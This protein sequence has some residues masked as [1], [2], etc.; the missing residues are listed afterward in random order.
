MRIKKIN[1][2][3]KKATLKDKITGIEL[4]TDDDHD[5][6]TLDFIYPGR[7]KY[8]TPDFLFYNVTYTSSKYK[9]NFKCR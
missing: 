6:V 9:S 2:V 1:T 8:R 4:F 7:F 5:I 3:P